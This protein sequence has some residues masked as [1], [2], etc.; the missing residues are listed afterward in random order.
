MGKRIA[1]K[2]RLRGLFV[3]PLWND[4]VDI[5]WEALYNYLHSPAGGNLPRERRECLGGILADV[6]DLK[7]ERAM[8]RTNVLPYLREVRA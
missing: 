7:K 5:L 3:L 6:Q 4:E 1:K 8:G 2:K